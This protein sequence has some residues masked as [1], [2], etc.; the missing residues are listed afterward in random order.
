[1]KKILII[2]DD[3]DLREAIKTV[4]APFYEI[5]EA[6]GRE[7]ALKVLKDYQPHLIILDVM[8]DTTSTGF[9][10]AREFRQDSRLKDTKLLMLTSVDSVMNINF[11]AEAGDPTWLPVDDYLTKPLQPKI[12]LD[13]IQNLIA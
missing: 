8:M 1:V 5:R 10:L 12:L 4:L 9:E 3:A 11:K 6:E 7:S 13:K 2:D